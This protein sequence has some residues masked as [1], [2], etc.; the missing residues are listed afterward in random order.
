MLKTFALRDGNLRDR[1]IGTFSYD[2][3]K[4]E[5]SMSVDD[6]VSLADLPLS[7]EI[8]VHRGNY[9]LGHEETLSWIRGRICPPGR[10]NIHEILS[11][12]G[13]AEYDEMKML[14]ATG[15]R[16]DRD[17]LYIEEQSS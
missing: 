15:A 2:T 16:C 7:I 3:E 9:S 4:K 1:Q 17:E 5:F 8:L 10:H 6:K 13:L 11:G 12:I 14:E